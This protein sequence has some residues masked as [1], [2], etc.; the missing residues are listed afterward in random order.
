M[1]L[2]Y[3]EYGLCGVVKE[4]IFCR[5]GQIGEVRSTVVLPVLAGAKLNFLLEG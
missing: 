1:S 4:S 2:P 5:M 3:Q